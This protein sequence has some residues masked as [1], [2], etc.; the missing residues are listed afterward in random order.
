V[1]SLKMNKAGIL[2]F[3]FLIALSPSF[4]ALQTNW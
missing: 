2:I 1:E 3:N 4:Q